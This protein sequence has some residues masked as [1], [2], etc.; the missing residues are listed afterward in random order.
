MGLRNA[1]ELRRDGDNESAEAIITAMGCT[2]LQQGKSGKTLFCYDERGSKYSMPLYLFE[3]PRNLVENKG[4]SKYDNSD[5]NDIN[6]QNDINSQKNEEIA[7]KVRLNIGR[8]LNVKMKQQDSIKKLKQYLSSELND[9]DPTK[10]RVIARGKM[11]SNSYKICDPF[12]IKNGDIIHA[13]FPSSLYK[14][15]EGH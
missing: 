3:E 4:L 11:L 12:P 8:D 1:V 6:D 7:F 10:I 13:S 14:D 9:L 2:Q 15:I 5:I